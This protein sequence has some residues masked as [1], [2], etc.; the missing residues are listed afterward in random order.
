[1]L[2]PEH[3]GWVVVV[4][5]HVSVS[6]RTCMSPSSQSSPRHCCKIYCKTALWEST[7]ALPSLR[8][9]PWQLLLYIPLQMRAMNQRDYRVEQKQRGRGG[10][11]RKSEVSWARGTGRVWGRRR[12]TGG[13][14]GSDWILLGI[15]LCILI[16]WETVFYFKLF[17][18]KIATRLKGWE[19]QH[20]LDI[21][22]WR[23]SICLQA[24]PQQNS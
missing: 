15:V 16:K 6:L 2:S 18:S 17:R 11:Q 9:A 8:T 20:L 24:S 21:G 23:V 5:L 7:H 10:G 14:S 12:T 1:M 19:E 4:G 13:A 22:A 3:W